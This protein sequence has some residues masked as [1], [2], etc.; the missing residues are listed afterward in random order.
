MREQPGKLKLINLKLG[1]TPRECWEVRAPSGC[2]EWNGLVQKP[3]AAIFN[4]CVPRIFKAC[5]T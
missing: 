5:N 3:R 1:E 4:R 2:C